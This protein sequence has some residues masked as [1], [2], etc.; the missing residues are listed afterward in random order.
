VW[1]DVDRGR[2]PAAGNSLST[3]RCV[4]VNKTGLVNEVKDRLGV[5]TA[6]AKTVVDAVFD[7]IAAALAQGEAI[8]LR[9][10][11]FTPDS[12][13]AWAAATD[14][15]A[16]PKPAAK[17]ASAKQA[18]AKKAAANGGPAKKAAA[19]PRAAEPVAVAPVEPH[20]VPYEPMHD[21]A[22]DAAAAAAAEQARP[23]LVAEPWD[24][25]TRVVAS[26]PEPEL[27]AEPDTLAYSSGEADT[28]ES[29]G[30]LTGR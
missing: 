30:D 9:G 7:E 23:E 11:G 2:T 27:L 8:T 26:M 29:I 25:S 5:S 13:K 4:P 18:P 14:Q 28:D 21:P 22:A 3:K 17:Q 19:R 16:K 15:V 10:F 24:E 20:V 12:D 1:S 6:R